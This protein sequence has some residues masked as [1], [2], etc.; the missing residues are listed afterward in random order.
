MILELR[1]GTGTRVVSPV[2]RRRQSTDRLEMA[3][4]LISEACHPSR[5]GHQPA[6]TR[7]ATDTHLRAAM[8]H[9][10]AAGTLMGGQ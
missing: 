10:S 5:M 6:S 2:L 9:L 7:A 8:G 4:R 1:P 3:Q